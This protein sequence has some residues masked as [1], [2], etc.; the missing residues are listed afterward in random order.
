[1]K[2][3]KRLSV[4]NLSSENNLLMFRLDGPVVIRT[5]VAENVNKCPLNWDLL[6]IVCVQV[7]APKVFLIQSS[8]MSTIQGFLMY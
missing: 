8:R 7:G 1:M 3:K 6:C 5:K 4:T 2:M